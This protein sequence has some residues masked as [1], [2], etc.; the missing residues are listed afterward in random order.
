MYTYYIF[1]IIKIEIIDLTNDDDQSNTNKRKRIESNYQNLYQQE[2]NNNLHTYFYQKEFYYRFGK[3]SWRW[4]IQL[5]NNHNH[6]LL[7]YS[8]KQE[9]N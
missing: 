6:K 1:H 2:V 9:K 4:G 3:R 7:V 5:L 8:N